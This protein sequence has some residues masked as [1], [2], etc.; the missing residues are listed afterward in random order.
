M[1][2]KSILRACVI[3]RDAVR[4]DPAVTGLELAVSERKSAN[5]TTLG[6]AST[7]Q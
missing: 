3:L 7:K 1:D 6:G 5:S 4:N 2:S